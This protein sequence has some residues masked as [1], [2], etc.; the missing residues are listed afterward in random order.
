LRICAAH[1][2]GYLPSYI[3]RSDAGCMA[4]PQTCPPTDPVLKK[5]PS[6]YM[7]QIYVDALVFTP[8]ATRH[9]AAVVG[10]RRMMIGTDTPIP[11]V[12]NPIE[13]VMTTPGLSDDDKRAI[14]GGTACRLLNIPV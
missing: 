6:E 14:L 1:G 3:D 10:A 11:W 13:T 9:L 5:K 12:S 4:N 8:E 7:K 2:G